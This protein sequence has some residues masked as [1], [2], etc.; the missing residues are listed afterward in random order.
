[1]VIEN[2]VLQKNVPTIPVSLYIHFPWCISKCPYCDFN[3]YP[4]ADKSLIAAYI[5]KLLYDLE[6]TAFSCENKE[7]V[8]IYFGGGTPSLLPP[9]AVAT[10][11]EHVKKYFSCALDTEISME[12]NPGTVDL[13]RCQEFKYAGINRLSLGVQSFDDEKLKSIKRVHNARGALAAVESVKKAGFTNFNLDLMYGLPGQTAKAAVADL[14]KALS[15]E[16]P[17]LS[18]YQLTLDD[19]RV[20]QTVTKAQLPY[21]E[22]LWHIQKAGQECLVTQKLQQYEVSAYCR[23]LNDR[24]KHNM[25]Y[26][27]YGDYMGIGA[28]AHGKITFSAHTI[29]RYAKIA[30]PSQYIDAKTLIASEEVVAKEKLPLEF[31]LNA[32]RLYQPISYDLLKDR[33]G[34]TISAIKKQ[35]QVA[36]NL[37][38]IAVRERERV[39]LT[40]ERGKNFLNDLLEIFL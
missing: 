30:V 38:L 32:L 14:K 34:F 16:P 3:S 2:T 4:L 37:G 20:L 7:L 11:I 31:M 12:A 40:T 27:L 18:W 35:L 26:W 29:K 24:C 23:T 17:H 25:N 13:T 33:T 1:M 28:G 22:K 39:I 8:S 15:F 36:E 19:P 6:C 21:G 9:E 5:N 10:I